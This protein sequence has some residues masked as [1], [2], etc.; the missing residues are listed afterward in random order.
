M[1]EA[2]K[3]FIRPI[4]PYMAIGAAGPIIVCTTSATLSFFI[5]F[6]MALFFKLGL[7][8][9]SVTFMA[10]ITF[11]LILICFISLWEDATKEVFARNR[12][13]QSQ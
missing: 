5:L 3:E 4:W 9:Y 12:L 6:Y 2:I 10:S 7:F 13:K 11:Y 8:W 1:K